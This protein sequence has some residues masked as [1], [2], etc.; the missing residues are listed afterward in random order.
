MMSPPLI[1]FNDV[2]KEFRFTPVLNGLSFSVQP[3]SVYGLLG[4]NG[5]G[6]TTA[7]RMILS[8]EQPTSGHVHVFGTPPEDLDDVER[9]RIAYAA[10]GQILPPYMTVA[11]VGR[12]VKSATPAFDDSLFT[13]LIEEGRVPF[14]KRV[15]AL[16]RG[17]KQRLRLSLAYARR[18]KVLVLDEPTEG[19]DT[20][21][22]FNLL[23]RVLDVVAEGDSCAIVSSHVLGDVERVVDRIG[24]LAGGRI[25]LEGEIDLLKERMQRIRLAW[26]G[27]DDPGPDLESTARADGAL[28]FQRDGRQAWFVTDRYSPEWLASFK[29]KFP[30]C[31]V[32]NDSLDLEEIFFE[33]LKD[34]R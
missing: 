17:L 11:E 15:R 22:R 18:P 6:K 12:F 4:R 28:T 32:E 14:D 1:E 20:V 8:M 33:L 19:L 25:V 5:A 31:V 10:G 2:T 9:S 3:G 27:A 26:G 23:K 7:L 29:R 34:E 30:G 21:V 13:E 16:S 24:L